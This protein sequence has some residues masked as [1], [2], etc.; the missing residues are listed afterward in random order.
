MTLEQFHNGLRILLNLDLHDLVAFGVIDTGD[1]NAWRAFQASPW[2]WMIRAEDRRCRNLW[3][4][5]QT[6]MVR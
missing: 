4:L 5:M 2:A 1:L 3:T 6:R